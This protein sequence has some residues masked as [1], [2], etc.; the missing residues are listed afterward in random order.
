MRDVRLRGDRRLQF[1]L[2]VYN[3]FNTAVINGQ[4]TQV[5]Y[6]SATDLDAS[7]L[8]DARERLD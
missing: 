3:A 8:R 5:Q 2:D 4:Q 6:N 1:R 7:Q